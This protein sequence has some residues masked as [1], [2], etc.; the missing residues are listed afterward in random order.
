MKRCIVER[1]TGL[2]A[3]TDSLS[4]IVFVVVSLLKFLPSHEIK[5]KQR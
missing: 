1:M 2:A 5:P 3:A 4:D